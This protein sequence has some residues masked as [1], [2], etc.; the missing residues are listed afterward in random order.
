MPRPTKY[1]QRQAYK[2]GIYT[3]SETITDGAASTRPE[4]T[5]E[6]SNASGAG[7]AFVVSNAKSEEMKN[8]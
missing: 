7:N 8:A 4:G 1:G 3:T 5:I 6:V 2:L